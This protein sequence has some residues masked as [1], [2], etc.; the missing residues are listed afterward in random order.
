M[1]EKG[2]EKKRK[3]KKRQKEKAREGRSARANK[4]P[5]SFY[6]IAFVLLSADTNNFSP[7]PLSKQTNKQT[8]K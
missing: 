7:F 6:W 1:R 2:K 8:N 4:N 3:E 5:L